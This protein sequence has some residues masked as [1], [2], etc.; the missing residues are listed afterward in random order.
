MGVFEDVK[1]K[2]MNKGLS[3]VFPEGEDERILGACARHLKDGIIKPVAL[4]NVENIK[5]LASEKGFDIEGLE[6]IDP[7]EYDIEDFVKKF[8]ERRKGKA[9]EEDARKILR[10]PNY[11]GTMMVYTDMVSGMVS[12]A[13][14]S[15]GETVRPALQIV[16]TKPGASRISGAM[17]MLGSEGEKYIFSDIAIN[18]TLDAE[19][20]ADVAITSAET[21]SLFDI[22]PKVALLSFSTK[23][24]A[25]SPEQEKVA[26]ATKIA[27]ERKP[28]LALDG[29]LQFDAALVPEVAEKKSPGSNVAGKANVF[30]F[31]D[32]Q[33]GNI[34]YK[35]AQR[36]GKFE[37]LGPILQGMAKP[38]N[39]LS[40]GCNEEDAYKLAV[41]TA[42]QAL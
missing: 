8:V 7:N 23:G 17:V 40:R 13:A 32:L 22:D 6:I 31:P 14:H 9:T 28:E 19:Q 33:A 20:M 21:A 4:G 37:A 41:I 10:D 35:I 39:D 36:L 25:S 18:I 5:K 38:I 15:T 3:I 29:E 24:S 11:F 34:G 26:E 30:V 42:A 2:V 1:K 27:K 16:K 12:G